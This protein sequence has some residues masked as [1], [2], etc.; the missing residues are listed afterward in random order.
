M[1]HN[2]RIQRTRKLAADSHRSMTRVVHAKSCK[3]TTTGQEIRYFKASSDFDPD[4]PNPFKD[5]GAYGLTWTCLIITDPWDP[6]DFI[7]CNKARDLFFYRL[8]RELQSIRWRVADFLRYENQQG[9]NVI[10][11]SPAGLSVDRLVEWALASTPGP[12]V[13][14]DTD[15]RYVVHSTSEQCGERILAEGEIESLSLLIAQGTMTEPRLGH[16][17]LSEPPEYA[18]YVNLG[19]CDSPWPEAVTSSNQKARFVDLN[20][21]YQPGH[22]F[23]FDAHKI[24]RRGLDVRTGGHIFCVKHRLPLDDFL[25]AVVSVEDVD[26]EH[27]RTWTPVSYV[28]EANRAFNA[29][30]G[31]V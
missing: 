24:I 21:P 23:Y 16:H 14:R 3:C 19:S 1:E 2:K 7:G 4:S 22:R 17:G 10:L 26:P 5:D 30:L 31:E 8:G 20:E 15:P 11:S 27:T 9:R 25:L 29:K 18:D 13:V 6:S 12:H 28:A